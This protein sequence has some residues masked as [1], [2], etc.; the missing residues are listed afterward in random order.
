[1]LVEFRV[2]NFRSIRDE[3]VLSMVASKDKQHAETHLISTSIKSIPSLV[4]ST[5]IYGPNASGKTNLINALAFFRGF[6]VDSATA[7]KPDQQLNVQPF[8]LD[9]DYINQPTELELTYILNGVRYQYGFK[10][11]KDKIYGEWLLVYKSPKPQLWFSRYLNEKTDQYEYDFGSYLSGNK[12]QWQELTRSNALYLSTAAQWNSEQLKP[13]FDYIGN[14]IAVFSSG[15]LPS[16]DTSVQ[17]LQNSNI[18]Q[19]LLNFLT[20]A[21]I[22]ISA[23]D[24]RFQKGVK[25]TVKF[26]SPTGA[27]EIHREETELAIPQFHHSTEDISAI[28]ELQDESLGT[29]RLFTLA[30]PLIDILK[31]GRILVIDELDSSLHTY[32]VQRLVSMFQSK[33]I[34]KAGAQLIFTT[35]DTALLK[36]EFF[37]R[38]QIW[39]AEKDNSQ[40]TT[41]YPL[42]DFSPRKKEALE[43]GY[44]MGLYGALPILN[45]TPK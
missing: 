14:E 22:S 40:A 23:I 2:K 30:G 32:I 6:V 34:N 15:V 25:Q 5:A 11:N 28:L 16:P 42:T 43:R 45:D 24:V 10:L 3:Q 36:T 8:R 29:Q 35:H 44:L 17:M 19:E 33:K 7:V 12:K 4:S 26:D 38:D 21:D 1:M 31:K 18:R 37:R 13:I 41:I 27:P 20:S 39:F 9:K